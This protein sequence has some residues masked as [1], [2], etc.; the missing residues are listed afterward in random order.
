MGGDN[1]QIEWEYNNI[2]AIKKIA[3]DL[4]IVL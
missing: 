3:K 1:R 2:L 4:E